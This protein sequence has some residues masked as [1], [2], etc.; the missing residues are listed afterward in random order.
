[1]GETVLS[2]GADGLLVKAH[3]LKFPAPYSCD[4]RTDKSR[5]TF[6]ILRAILRPYF[7]LSMVRGQGLKMLPLP[8][9]TCGIA[10][11]RESKR[12]IEVILR[13]LQICWYAPKQPLRP[14]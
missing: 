3:G 11:R 12:A 2:C 5:A 14:R 4:L 13:R 10:A 7:E 6:E 1:M 8:V 9:R